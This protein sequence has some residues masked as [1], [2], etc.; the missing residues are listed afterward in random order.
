M[1][2]FLLQLHQEINSSLFLLDSF[3]FCQ[4]FN[5]TREK[6]SVC[7]SELKW[8]CFFPCF[9]YMCNG[10]QIGFCLI[11]KESVFYVSKENLDLCPKRL[12]SLKMKLQS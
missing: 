1:I 3:T 2:A 10:I 5:I 11:H 6:S 12:F 7:V 9:L 8:V 4:T